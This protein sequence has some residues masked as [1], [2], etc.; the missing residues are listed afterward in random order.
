M[1]VVDLEMSKF[2]SGK[3][4]EG[5]TNEL[6]NNRSAELQC[7]TRYLLDFSTLSIRSFFTWYKLISELAA[8]KNRSEY[9]GNQ[10][11]STTVCDILMRIF[12]RIYT[13]LQ[14]GT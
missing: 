14:V 4:G 5:R 6:V 9:F 11:S 13:T 3:N 10:C 7:N 2:M 1:A 8:V 12:Y